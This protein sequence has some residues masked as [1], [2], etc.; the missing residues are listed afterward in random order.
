MANE[1]QNEQLRKEA[2]RLKEIKSD[3]IVRFHEFKPSPNKM[4]EKCSLLIFK[5]NFQALVYNN[6]IL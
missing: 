1:L 4:Y 2:N 6:G 3:F 5:K